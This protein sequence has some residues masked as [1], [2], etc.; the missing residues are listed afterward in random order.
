MKKF[1]AISVAI[2]AQLVLSSAFAS[3]GERQVIATLQGHGK[4]FS[5]VTLQEGGSLTVVGAETSLVSTRKLG[6]LTLTKLVGLAHQ[7]ANAGVK[8][9]TNEFVCMT[10]AMVPSADLSVAALNQGTYQFEGAPR[11]LLTE[12]GCSFH[13]MTFPIQAQ[14]QQNAEILKEMLELLAVDT[15]ENQ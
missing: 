1:T 9:V 3:T 4:N 13:Q 2:V 14:D 6:E 8:T 11:L 10:F 7:V 12:R 15:V 5:R